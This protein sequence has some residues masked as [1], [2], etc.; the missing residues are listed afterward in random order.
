MI[1]KLD[2]KTFCNI[3]D[4][5]KETFKHE[6]MVEEALDKLGISINDISLPVFKYGEKIIED[7]FDSNDC[8]LIFEFC[9][10]VNSEPPIVKLHGVEIPIYTANDLYN[11]LIYEEPST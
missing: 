6:M 9:Y 10:P 7:N 2:K 8:E 1:N 3:I 5:L 4:M 11:I